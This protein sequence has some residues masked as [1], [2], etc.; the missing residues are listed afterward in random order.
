MGSSGQGAATGGRVRLRRQRRGAGRPRPTAGPAPSRPVPGLAVRET[1]AGAAR[2]GW[3]SRW[4][5]LAIAVTVSLAAAVIE[6]AGHTL[7]DR[8]FLPLAISA[9]LTAT[10]VNLLGLVLLSGVLAQLVRESRGGRAVTVREV[11]ASLA[12]SRLIRADLLASLVVLV[13]LVVLIVPGLVAF[14]FLALVGPVIEAE[15]RPVLAALRRSAHLVRPHF[16][17]VVLLATLPALLISLIPADLTESVSVPGVLAFLAIRGIGEGIAEAAAG[18]VLVELRYR[19][20]EADSARSARAA[21]S[22]PA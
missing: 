12:W 17:W 6:V 5:I 9:D 4:R 1:L 10:M 20:A 14:T 19:L 15:N 11:L 7:I 3:Q 18:L 16:W 22:A 8:S 13:G 2:A 21:R